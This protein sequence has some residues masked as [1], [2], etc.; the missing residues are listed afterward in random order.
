MP[1][2][3][4]FP[5]CG[6]RKDPSTGEC[7]GTAADQPKPRGPDDRPTLPDLAA[8]M[9]SQ[10]ALL[11]GI[12]GLQVAQELAVF[13]KSLDAD[14][15]NALRFLD[16]TFE[17]RGGAAGELL[18]DI[19]RLVQPSS[20]RPKILEAVDAATKRRRPPVLEQLDA[21]IRKRCP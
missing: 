17:R 18:A 6:K 12:V 5:G 1:H 3:L 20:R 15:R 2:P 4:N 21:M 10:T 14:P 7:A 9:R 11:R 13:R 19:D 16:R 8:E